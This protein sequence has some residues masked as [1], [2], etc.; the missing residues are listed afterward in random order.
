MSDKKCSYC[1]ENIS[2]D[3]VETMPDGEE[4]SFCSAECA[5]DQYREELDRHGD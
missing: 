2:E 3:Y 4:K 5:R 1:G